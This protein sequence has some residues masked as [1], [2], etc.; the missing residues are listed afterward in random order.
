VVNPGMIVVTRSR[1]KEDY[2]KEVTHLNNT[3]TL[4]TGVTTYWTTF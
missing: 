1:W 2:W 4:I 3:M